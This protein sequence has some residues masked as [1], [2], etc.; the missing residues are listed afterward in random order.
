MTIIGMRD[1]KG[2]TNRT[3]PMEDMKHVDRFALVE[4]RVVLALRH[5]QGI[6]G[7]YYYSRIFQGNIGKP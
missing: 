2:T 3:Q 6:Q 1:A 5:E 7:K 4:G